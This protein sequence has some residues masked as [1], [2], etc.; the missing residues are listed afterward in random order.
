MLGGRGDP[1]TEEYSFL[2]RTKETPEG[3]DFCLRLDNDCMEPFLMR[4]ELLY[5]DRHGAPEELQP[6]LFWYGGRV[7]C[8][9]W[10][11]DS[12]GTLHLL[13][14]NPKR[15][16]ENLSLSKSEKAACLCLGRVVLKKRLP[17]PIY[18]T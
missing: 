18:R 1:M 10:C 7:L 12:A 9:Q 8:R 6:G 5:I 4:G 17:I 3:A 16:S 11:E 13:C 15:E 2:P 14:A